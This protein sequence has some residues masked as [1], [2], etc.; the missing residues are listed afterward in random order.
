[1]A[2]THEELPSFFLSDVR[3][4]TGSKLI[5]KGFIHVKQGKIEEINQGQLPSPLPADTLVL[6]RP[7]YT[8]IAGLIDAHLHALSGDVNSIEKSFRFG[9]TTVCDMH[10]DPK[11]NSK[12]RELAR[13]PKLKSKYADFKYA[14]L[15]AIV[16]DGWPIPVMRKEFEKI[17][18][19]G[20]IVDKIIS[21]WP[22]LKAPE[23]AA[24]FVKQQVEHG[25]SYIKMFNELGDTVG[26]NLPRPLMDIQKAVVA[27]AHKHGVLAVGHAFSYSG[28]LDLL[29]AGVDGLTHMF[30]DEPP[31]SDYI[32]VMLD[33][34]QH[35]NPTLGLC[36]SNTDEGSERQELFAKD[37]FAQR[38]LIQQGPGESL[39]LAAA[40]RPQASVRYAYS[41]TA[42]LYNAGVPIVVGTDSS[43]NGLGLH[44]EMYT[45]VED[46]GMSPLD[47]LKSAT[48]ITVDRFGFT[49]RG[50]LEKGRK[51][52]TVLVE[53]DVVAALADPKVLC[54]PIAG[55]WRDGVLAQVYE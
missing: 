46:V 38:M 16:E 4:F 45:M 41:S 14:G 8:V 51:A 37:P 49:D 29:N 23:D 9:V 28:A 53:G 19:G 34:R 39:G 32:R 50:K 25:A 26:M 52:D 40:Q 22:K 31:I 55:V 35:C 27:A 17:P 3:I 48:S 11:D 30:L 2:N 6:S 43:G 5:D 15:G 1:M 12:I 42:A 33:R 10:N 47:V 13:D 7:G 36:A 54:L 24:P 21:A 20:Q 18:C 44:L